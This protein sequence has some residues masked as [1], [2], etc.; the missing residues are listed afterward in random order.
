MACKTSSRS[1]RNSSE[2]WTIASP[3]SCTAA[4]TTSRSPRSS[5]EARHSDHPWCRTACR[6]NARSPRSSGDAFAN[7]QSHPILAAACAM[8]WPSPRSLADASVMCA[9]LLKASSTTSLSSRSS[10]AANLSAVPFFL[11]ACRTIRRSPRSSSDANCRAQPCRSMARVRT[12]A[13]P[14]IQSGAVASSTLHSCASRTISSH[15][16]CSGA[17]RTRRRLSGCFCPTA[18][19][20]SC[21]PSVHAS[22]SSSWPKKRRCS[23][24]GTSARTSTAALT[25]A[26]VHRE[27]ARRSH[28]E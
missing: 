24:M 28:R 27:S 9:P 10:S 11:T 14:R 7:A 15:F 19:C 5:A 26:V 23:R 6:T 22:R 13:S 18:E 21:F 1:A 12:S 8:N 4:R 25:S 2:A 20:G 16:A 17:R 3:F